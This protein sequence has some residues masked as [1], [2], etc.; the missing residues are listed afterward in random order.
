MFD[1]RHYVPMLKWRTAEQQALEK[2][3]TNR[4]N[5]ITPLIQLVMPPV[6]KLKK[7]E[8]EKTPK[9]I[10]TESIELLNTKAPEFPKQIQRC[11]GQKP[12][13]VDP[14]LLY[15]SDIRARILNKIAAT[16]EELDL[17]I[18]PVVN[19]SSDD[20]MKKTVCS[21]MHKYNKGACLKLV[22]VDFSDYKQLKRDIR[23][24]IEDTKLEEKNIDLIID[25][26]E[27]KGDEYFNISKLSQE[28]PNLKDWRT[29]TLT[30]GA[31]PI[32]LSACKVDKK[33]LIPR[34]DW[35]NWVDLITQKKLERYPAFS[36]YTVRHPIHKEST[37]FFS[38]SA[39]ICYTLENDWLIMRGQKAQSM[40]YLANAKLLSSMPEFFGPDFSRGDQF[41]AAKGNYFDDY[42]KHPEKKG[43][44]NATMWIEAGINHHLACTVNQIANLP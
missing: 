16:G 11:W 34:K 4:K 33:N 2:L 10:M 30:C 41:I 36:D 25:L 1:S 40:Q 18:I 22:S 42:I 28:L 5:F 21:I 37:L 44:G 13:F 43:T 39:S 23:K 27:D 8:K 20:D 14:S 29:F 31:F 26:Q 32:D 38:P 7:D 6:R 3:D 24:F 12:I 35:C 17:S 19:L 9:E 15:T